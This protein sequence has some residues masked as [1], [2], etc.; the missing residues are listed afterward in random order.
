MAGAAQLSANSF[1][2]RLALVEVLRDGDRSAQ[3]DY[4]GRTTADRSALSM[5]NIKFFR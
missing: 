5:D 3:R 4:C 2:R 1:W